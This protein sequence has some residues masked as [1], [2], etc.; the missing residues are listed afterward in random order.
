MFFVEESE[1]QIGNEYLQDWQN[2]RL[3]GGWMP[4]IDNEYP[5]PGMWMNEWINASQLSSPFW[6]RREQRFLFL[7]HFKQLVYD[8]HAGYT[9]TLNYNTVRTYDDFTVIYLT[10]GVCFKH[11]SNYN[12]YFRFLSFNLSLFFLLPFSL[13]QIKYGS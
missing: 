12:F 6:S 10:K 7:L 2:N 5:H 8:W 1:S 3:W 11:I 4:R 9:S 13:C